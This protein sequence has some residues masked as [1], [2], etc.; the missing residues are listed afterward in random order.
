[1]GRM[2]KDDF[3]KLFFDLVQI[4]SPSG[5]EL[6]IAEYIIKKISALPNITYSSDDAGKTFGG[7]CG[8]LLVSF[9]GK[10]KKRTP[11]ALLSHMDTVEPSKGVIPKL[12]ENGRIFA[13]SDTI[14]GA[15]DKCAIAIKLMLLEKASSQPEKFGD[16][17]FIF[18][19]G[20]EKHLLGSTALDVSRFKAKECLILD[21][22]KPVGSM[23]TSAPTAVGLKI[24]VKGKPAHAG[25]EPE[26]G[27]SALT[28]AAK[29]ILAAPLGR[30]SPVTTSN[31]GK[32]VGGEAVNIVMENVEIDGEARSLE[33]K[34]L[35]KVVQE[36]TSAFESSAEQMGGSVSCTVDDFFQGYKIAEET[37]LVQKLSK[38]IRE[39]GLQPQYLSTGGGSDANVLNAKGIISLNLGLAFQ[40]PHSKDEYI[41]LDDASK[42]Y[43]ILE[44][45]LQLV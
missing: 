23:I 11:I 15:D 36:I 39:Q 35:D 25:V 37:E 32:I 30:I 21:S 6:P 5:G 17:E 19:V 18:T 3:I 8:N 20:E 22:N 40:N 28:I 1:M 4:Y 44:N 41:M 26:K 34:E 10:N 14:L 7:N 9:S 45:F 24:K 16:I 42:S 29:G 12:D 33:K 38:A 27:I 13:E 2:N 31:L 43:D